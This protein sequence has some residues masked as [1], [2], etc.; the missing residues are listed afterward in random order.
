MFSSSGVG[1]GVRIVMILGGVLIAALV[2]GALLVDEGEVVVLT[3]TAPDGALYETQLWIV[4]HEN[5][6]YLRAASPKAR[7]LERIRGSSSVMLLRGTARQEWLAVPLSSEALRDAVDQA[8]TRKYGTADRLWRY[9]RDG[10]QTVPIR[11]DPSSPLGNG[12]HP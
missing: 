6:L 3:T 8:M 1:S 12:T 9:F 7:W 11:L 2:G 5:S 4:E 10:S